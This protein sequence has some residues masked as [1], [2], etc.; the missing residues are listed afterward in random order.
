LKQIFD[1]EMGKKNALES[2]AIATK[3]KITTAKTL[4]SSLSGEKD[5][6]AKGSMAISDDKKRLVGNSSL[7]CAFISYCGPFNAEYRNILKEEYFIKD[8]KNRNI[9]LKSDLA[10][11]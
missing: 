6:W 11:T 8:M 2:K 7:S 1:G 3:K 5:R 4:I 9:P 10:L